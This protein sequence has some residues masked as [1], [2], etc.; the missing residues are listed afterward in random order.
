MELTRAIP[1]DAAAL[2]RIAQAAKRHWGYSEHWITQWSAALTVTAEF[3][4][5]HP[6]VVARI[7]GQPVGF[8]A[9]TGLGQQLRLEHLWVLPEYMR[10]GIGRALFH[11]LARLG[12][13]AGWSTLQ[14]VSDPNAEGFYLRL[15]AKRIGEEISDL[16]GH[17]RALPV[18]LVNLPPTG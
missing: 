15:G 14:I 11:E 16:D 3:I 2:T 8:A 12:R 6:T 4:T 17:R 10:R 5:T 1:A 18:L 13:V 9:L 7:E